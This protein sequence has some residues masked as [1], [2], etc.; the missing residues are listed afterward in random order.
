MFGGGSEM[1]HYTGVPMNDLAQ[2]FAKNALTKLQQDDTISEYA[3]STSSD[4]T[5]VSNYRPFKSNRNKNVI[6]RGSGGARQQVVTRDVGIEY[7]VGRFNSMHQDQKHLTR[8]ITHKQPQW[9]GSQ[10]D[11]NFFNACNGAVV[12]LKDQPNYAPAVDSSFE[13]NRLISS[14]FDHVYGINNNGETES[15]RGLLFNE[16]EYLMAVANTNRRITIVESGYLTQN[17]VDFGVLLEECLHNCE[18]Y[19]RKYFPTVT[20]VDYTFYNDLCIEMIHGSSIP[21]QE[22]IEYAIQ[23]NLR[24]RDCDTIDGVQNIYVRNIA[25]HFTLFAIFDVCYFHITFLMYCVL[26]EFS[27]FYK[28]ACKST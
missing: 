12:W 24:P 1:S 22:C 18:D 26:S 13:N 6:L 10:Y 9:A 20:S 27:A 11:V 15:E 23:N 25:C 17:G 21:L 7:L 16:K 3:G 5:F 14:C 2:T 4:I 8:F 28:P 19:A